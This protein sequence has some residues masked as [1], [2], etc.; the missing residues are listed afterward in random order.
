MELNNDSI[1]LAVNKKFTEF[2]KN[3][4]DVM[5]HKM[6]NHDISKTYV[7]SMNQISDMKSAYKN[8]SGEDNE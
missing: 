7:Q 8:I 6:A 3:I 2:E 4:K 1:N 5:L